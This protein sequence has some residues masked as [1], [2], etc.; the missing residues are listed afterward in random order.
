[1]IVEPT[2]TRRRPEQ[3]GGCDAYLSQPSQQRGSPFE[4]EEL[5]PGGMLE[6]PSEAPWSNQ[7]Q[8]L[9]IG[10]PW[11]RRIAGEESSL[12]RAKACHGKAFGTG[13]DLT[14]LHLVIAPARSRS[15]IEQNRDN[16]Q[17]DLRSRGFGCVGA[18]RDKSR[19]VD[20]A[21]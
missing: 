1:M 13:Q 16:G 3:C 17:I 2:E 4:A 10:A 6:R 8:R 14:G 5:V 11:D 15:G 19:A 7:G 18:G 9:G 12:H 20:S 21:G